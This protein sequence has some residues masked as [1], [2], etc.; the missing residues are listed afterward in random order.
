MKKK[1]LFIVLLVFSVFL[2]SCSNIGPT[3]FEKAT[4]TIAPPMV[5]TPSQT[6]VPTASETPISVQE[7]SQAC[8]EIDMNNVSG[9]S[10]KGVAVFNNLSQELV[11]TLFLQDLETASV[12]MGADPNSL[13]NFWGVSLDRK[14]ILYEYERPAGDDSDYR[15][16]VA[17]FRGQIIKEFDTQFPG[18]PYIANYY[19]WQNNENIRVV[20]FSESQEAFRMSPRTYNPFTGEY[21]ILRTDFPDSVGKDLDW[22]LDWIALSTL[23][24]E[25]ANI[26]Y[27]PSLTR[28]LY[29]RNS[30]SISLTDV[31]TGKELAS[32]YLPNW[33]RLPRWS[34]DGSY[35]SIIGTAKSNATR[36]SDEFYIIS[37]DGG[38]FKRLTYLSNTFEQ[39]AIAD[40]SWS[41]DGKKIAFWSYTEPGDPNA[42]GTQSE[43]MILDTTTGE[44]TN[45]C[46]QGISAITHLNDVVLF[47]HVEPIWSP[48]GSQIMISQWDTTPGQNNK[49][50]D[51]L[52]IDIPS[53][54]GVKINENKQP[55][56]WM[57][58]EP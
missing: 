20:L 35:L 30:E 36:A 49:N 37:K 23:H 33:G 47:S 11:N 29:P 54:T 39:S 38:E 27:D 5:F 17:D 50:Y 55:A 48:D 41:P 56:G 7:I 15:L 43:L 52:V 1:T 4:S 18:D 10:L 2:A 32:L 14:Y 28:V 9:V 21:R 44:V 22:G 58:K 40:Y 51:V 26:V 25:G 34:P 31:E 13:V 16:I 8:V 57:I 6:S 19:N 46:I 12:K 53:L 42:E 3:Q 45:L 24:L